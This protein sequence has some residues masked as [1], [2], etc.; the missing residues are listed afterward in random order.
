[1]D[2]FG[3]YFVNEDEVVL[4]YKKY[5]F[6]STLHWNTKKKKIF[7]TKMFNWPP[8]L[9][10]LYERYG[11][12]KFCAVLFLSLTFPIDVKSFIAYQES[13]HQVNRFLKRDWLETSTSTLSCKVETDFSDLKKHTLGKS[14][15]TELSSGKRRFDWKRSTF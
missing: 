4:A 2:L 8:S 6:F 1:M 7:P 12:Q 14:N 15:S 3:S 5:L 10:W 9:V 13:W 11:W